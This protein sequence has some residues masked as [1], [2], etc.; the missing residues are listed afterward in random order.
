VQIRSRL[1]FKEIIG[2]FVPP[3]IALATRH[4]ER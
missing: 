1:F 2:L 3:R 4:A